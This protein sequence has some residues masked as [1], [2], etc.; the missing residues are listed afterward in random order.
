MAGGRRAAAA[1]PSAIDAYSRTDESLIEQDS[2][3][4]RGSSSSCSPPPARGYWFG[5]QRAPRRPARP[6][7][8]PR[9]R[10]GRP[11]PA[12][13]GR[14][15]SKR[16]RSRLQP[17]P[18][19]ITAVGS[20]RSDESVTLRPEVAGRISAIRF[21]EGQ[22]VAQGRAARAA[23]PCGQRRPKCEQA[24]RQPDARQEQVRP[25]RR[26]RQEQLH[27]G[28][29]EGRGREQPARSREAD[30]AAR[31]RRSSPRRRSRRRSPA[32]SACASCR[33][34]DYVKEGADIVNLESIDPLKVDFRV[35]EI[36]LRAG[37]GRA[38]RC[39]SRSTRCPARR[40]TAR[41]S[42][43]IR[44]STPPAARS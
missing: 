10:Q 11:R 25:R 43:S 26:P 32:S 2:R 20:L 22:R 4:R 39:R 12:A 16:P 40:S 33:V 15:P 28:P 17:M 23:R 7:P 19:T 9:R 8:A 13:A 21:Q 5:T 1:L 41:C 37:A 38:S 30:A 34:G 36:Y 6:R 27:L 24:Q 31:P 14:S 29:G 44:W 35:P 18:Q 3:H 42:R